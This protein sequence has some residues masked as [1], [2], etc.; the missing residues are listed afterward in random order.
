MLIF[1]L[2]TSKSSYILLKCGTYLKSWPDIGVLL[3]MHA[4]CHCKRYT[5]ICQPSYLES[6]WDFCRY[7]HFNNGKICCYIHCHGWQPIIGTQLII[8]LLFAAGVAFTKHLVHL[9]SYNSS[10]ELNQQSEVRLYFSF[11]FTYLI[12]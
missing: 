10:N 7:V 4:G 1:S 6:R 8:S 3:N 9:Y 12:W 11:S 2:G 5:N